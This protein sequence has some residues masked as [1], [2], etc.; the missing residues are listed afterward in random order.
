[1]TER[2]Q[3][4]EECDEAAAYRDVAVYERDDLAYRLVLTQSE[5]N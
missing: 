4:T 5:T 3:A 2:N 1:M